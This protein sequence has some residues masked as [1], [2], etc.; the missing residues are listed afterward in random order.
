MQTHFT[1]ENDLSAAVKH[2]LDKLNEIGVISTLH[3]HVPN[4]FKPH[5]NFQAAWAKKKKVGCL[6]GAPDWVIVWS[7]GTLLLELKHAKTMKAAL[8]KMRDNQKEV[9]RECD[10]KGINYFIVYDY[11]TFKA[12]LEKVGLIHLS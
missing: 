6:G 4:E 5:K 11:E 3:F 1:S 10:E 8:K 12:A 9:A 7:G 2:W